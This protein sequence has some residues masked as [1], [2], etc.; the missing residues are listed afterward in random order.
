MEGYNDPTVS[1]ILESLLLGVIEKDNAQTTELFNPDSEIVSGTPELMTNVHFK[2]PVAVV[3]E[4][5]Q[6]SEKIVDDT[7]SICSCDSSDEEP[8]VFQDTFD[9]KNLKSEMFYNPDNT[10]GEIELPMPIYQ[11]MEET[12]MQVHKDG[13]DIDTSSEDQINNVEKMQKVA[14]DHAGIPCLTINNM[15]C[16]FTVNNALPEQCRMENEDKGCDSSQDLC[17][18]EPAENGPKVALDA[19]MQMQLGDPS[20]ESSNLQQ[21]GVFSHIQEGESTE[22]TLIRS[23]HLEKQNLE[24]DEHDPQSN[25]LDDVSELKRKCASPEQIDVMSKRMKCSD[26]TS[27]LGKRKQCEEKQLGSVKSKQLKLTDD[28]LINQDCL[29]SPKTLKQLAASLLDADEDNAILD[30]NNKD[31]Y[32]QTTKSQ[33]VSMNCD[34][35][36]NPPNSQQVSVENDQSN[37]GKEDL[38]NQ[39]YVLSEMDKNEHEHSPP[40]M[41]ADAPM[42]KSA[43]YLSEPNAVEKTQTNCLNVL[44]QR[45]SSQE[46]TAYETMKILALLK[47][48]MDD[49]IHTIELEEPRK[50]QHFEDAVF[51]HKE[52]CQKQ[53]LEV[54]SQQ[55]DLGPEDVELGGDNVHEINE[56]EASLLHG[57]NADQM[58][59]DEE[60][61]EAEYSEVE[62]SYGA[63]MAENAHD[64]A[65]GTTMQS[66]KHALDTISHKSVLVCTAGN[67]EQLTIQTITE[68]QAS[69]DM[70]KVSVLPFKVM[71][72]DNISKEEVGKQLSQQDSYTEVKDTMT[73][74]HLEASAIET[75]NTETNNLLM[76][77]T[78]NTE[79]QNVAVLLNI[80]EKDD[81]VTCTQES[82]AIT[83]TY[84]LEARETSD[85]CSVQLKKHINSETMNEYEV[86]NPTAEREI[87]SSFIDGNEMH[88]SFAMFDLTEV[89][90]ETMVDDACVP[91]ILECKQQNENLEIPTVPSCP[92]DPETG[93]Q[94]YENTDNCSPES[95]KEISECDLFSVENTGIEKSIDVDI[96]EDKTVNVQKCYQ[97]IGLSVPTF[98]DGWEIKQENLDM[99]KEP[100]NNDKEI[101]NVDDI[102][103]EL[104]ISRS[105]DQCCE[106]VSAFQVL[107]Q[108]SQNSGSTGFPMNSN[109]ITLEDIDTRSQDSI[110]YIQNGQIEISNEDC[111]ES[112]E[113]KPEKSQSFMETSEKLQEVGKYL[114]MKF[115]FHFTLKFYKKP[116]MENYSILSLFIRFVFHIGTSF[117]NLKTFKDFIY[118]FMKLFLP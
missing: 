112:T 19:K 57:C 7:Q 41:N 101:R 49:I 18:D 85:S 23:Q 20:T 31:L 87:I 45:S 39:S 69:D 30:I 118:C 84:L 5:E 3:H 94:K 83:E 82:M 63:V 70:T 44:K 25:V 35:I 24:I 117:S 68:E 8:G 77:I 14:C 115:L 116:F 43:N 59:V 108:Q 65:V 91:T 4:F 16:I 48:I 17:S 36:L 67:E 26:P 80:D 28:R 11:S 46:Q 32:Q 110:P 90:N 92:D 106:F 42:Q 21:I 76:N 71:E 6:L 61:T 50:S 81:N 74:N 100:S 40:S 109:K 103:S 72:E 29:F 78:Q 60:E 105:Q 98:E 75:K 34:E 104:P 10:I 12:L 107:S 111:H 73:S 54:P 2:S 53:L 9:T 113:Y 15:A 95:K 33:K 27:L 86:R 102:D 66:Q 62:H 79:I 13:H 51:R 55:K 1:G 97:H 37:D 93:L 58:V 52:A 38:S 89:E 96:Q 114:F 56:M 22:L 64:D 88:E 99:N 47:T